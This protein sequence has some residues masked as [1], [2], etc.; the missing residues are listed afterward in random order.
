M[1]QENRSY[2]IR[3]Q[4]GNHEPMIH[5]DMEQTIDTFEI[6]S[7]KISQTSAY[8]LMNSD[9]GLIVGRVVANGGFGVPNAKVSVFVPYENTEDMKKRLMYYYTS[10]RDTNT[11]GIRYNL[12]P[13][14]LD[15]VCHQ[16]VGTFPDKRVLLDNDSWIEIF[17]KYY[18]YTTRTNN[19]GDYMIYGAPIGTQTIHVDVDLSDIGVLSQRPRDMVYKGANINQFE[20]PNKFRVDTNLSSLAQ[21]FTEDKTIYVYPFW[22]DTTDSDTGA[23]VTR[24]DI[25]LSYKFEPTCIFMGSII[26]DTGENSLSKKCVAHKNQGKMSDMITGQGTIEMIRKTPD[27]KIEQYSVQGNQLIDS[28]GVW[29]YQIPMNLDYV[30]TDEF[31]NTVLTDDPNKGIATRARVRFRIGMTETGT[32]ETARKRARFLVP[33]NPRLVEEDYPKFS[34]TKEIDYEFG[35][36]TKDENFRDLL[37]NKV[38]TVKSYIPRLQKSVQPQNKK[39][40]GIKMVNHSGGNN[41]MPF[42]NLSIKF[43][44]TYMFL[45]ALLKVLVTVVRLTNQLICGIGWVFYSLFDMCTTIANNIN[46]E[47]VYILLYGFNNID[48]DDWKRGDF[49]TCTYL[50]WYDEEYGTNLSRPYTTTGLGKWFLKGAFNIGCGIILEG[51]CEDENGN[52]TSYAPGS[53]KLIKKLNWELK[54]DD[55]ALEYNDAQTN[56]RKEAFSCSPD[57]AELYNCIENQLAQDNEV[58]SFNFVNDWVNGVLYMPLWFR[59]IK[60]KRRFLFFNL[61]A[62]DQWCSSDKRNGKGIFQRDLKLYRTCA[63]AMDIEKDEEYQLKPLAADY[64]TTKV[65]KY[66]SERNPETGEEHTDFTKKDDSN[67]YGYQCHKESRS[68]IPIDYGIITEKETIYGE[69]V[70][71]YRPVDINFS[72]VSDIVTLY[73]TDIIL[74]GSLNDC[75]LHGIPQFFK[76]LSSTTYN[77]PSD[78]L[79][80]DFIYE[81]SADN[82]TVDKYSMK[83]TE[84]TGSDWGNLGDDQSGSKESKTTN[85][86]DNGGLFYGI[87]CFDSYTKPKSCINLSRICEFGV[88]LDESQEILNLKLVD[89]TSTEDEIYD[90]YETLI[91]DGY[92]SYDEIYDMDYRSMFATLNGNWLKTKVNDNTGLTEYDFNR[93]YVENF[94]GVLH[95]IME[96]TVTQKPTDTNSKATYAGNYNLEQY[97][98]D[99]MKFRYGAYEKANGKYLYFYDYYKTLRGAGL[100]KIE[101]NN[102]RFPRFENS[103]YFYFGLNEGKT[104]IDKFRTNYFAECTNDTK[105]ELAYNITFVPNPWCGDES[106]YIKFDTN[107]PTPISVILTDKNNPNN[108]YTATNINTEKFYVGKEQESNIDGYKYI[109]LLGNNNNEIA[110]L[111]TGEYK[112]TLIDGEEEEYH[113]TIS[114]NSE[115]INYKYNT[116]AFIYNGSELENKYLK[117]YVNGQIDWRTTFTDIAED[118]TIN[119]LSNNRVIGGAIIIENVTVDLFKIY[120]KPVNSEFFGYMEYVKFIKDTNNPADDEIYPIFYDENS[121]EYAYYDSNNDKI[122]VGSKNND[123]NI[124]WDN[125]I[126]N[127]NPKYEYNSNYDGLE[128]VIV[129]ND[130][131]YVILKKNGIGYVNTISSTSSTILGNTI[132]IGVPYCDQKY[133]VEVV[134]I[135]GTTDEEGNVSFEDVD[136][137]NS[138]INTV[139][140]YSRVFTM[141]ING[142]DYDLIRNFKTGWVEKTVQY[143]DEEYQVQYDSDGN[144]ITN[145]NF[146]NNNIY[147]WN[148]LDNIGK[149]VLKEGDVKSITE[150]FDGDSLKSS[151]IDENNEIKY[152]NELMLI[153]DTLSVNFEGNG[154]LIYKKVSIINSADPL[155]PPVQKIVEYST[156]YSWNNSYCYNADE[157]ESDKLSLNNPETDITN[158]IEKMDEIIKNRIE[159]TKQVKG[160]F[161][162]EQDGKT[163]TVTYKSTAT[164]IDYRCVGNQF[165]INNEINK[166]NPGETSGGNISV[167]TVDITKMVGNFQIIGDKTTDEVVS[168]LP[169]LTFEDNSY[170]NYDECNN[171]YNLQYKLPYYFRIIDNNNNTLPSKGNDSDFQAMVPGNTENEAAILNVSTMFGVHIYNKPMYFKVVRYWSRFNNYNYN[172]HLVDLPGFLKGN[173]V[174]GIEDP[175]VNISDKPDN[176]LY[177]IVDNPYTNTEVERYIYTDNSQSDKL[178]YGKYNINDGNNNDGTDI[179]DSEGDDEVVNG[180]ITPIDNDSNSTNSNNLYQYIEIDNTNNKTVVISDGYCSDYETELNFD[181]NIDISGTYFMYRV[182]QNDRNEYLDYVKL[183]VNNAPSNNVKYYVYSYVNDNNGNSNYVYDNLT[184]NKSKWDSEEEIND[185]FITKYFNTLMV[186]GNNTCI[187]TTMNNRWSLNNINTNSIIPEYYVPLSNLDWNKNTTYKKNDYV[188]YSNKIYVSL[189]NDN[190]DKNP[191]EN[192][193]YWKEVSTSRTDKL[194]QQT[195]KFF[196]LAACDDKYYSLSPVIDY[197][198]IRCFALWYKKA[199]TIDNKLVKKN[200]NKTTIY[201]SC[202]ID[203]EGTDEQGNPIT[204]SWSDYSNIQY[205]KEGNTITLTIPQYNDDLVNQID[206]E[207]RDIFTKNISIKT[208]N[209]VNIKIQD[210]EKKT[211]EQGEETEVVVIKREKLRVIKIEF[212]DELEIADWHNFNIIDCMGIRRRCIMDHNSIITE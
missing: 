154:K 66:E 71:Y 135:C 152:K 50:E 129:K 57:V 106:G 138:L 103:F 72:N 126:I 175:V 87:T 156:P 91:P 113:D 177:K 32:E 78:L 153:G 176:V 41:P 63:Q 172:G 69:H 130:G 128:M 165:G 181:F 9:S 121:N 144:I 98:Q 45:C 30:I 211:N 200:Q 193:S 80:E 167:V 146:N 110:N 14:Q 191:A 33:N 168:N 212:G 21:I 2:R 169:T 166:T 11:Q 210:I 109:K 133:K 149:I 188:K 145:N 190:I 89:N 55:H 178:H 131:G 95:D 77:M 171:T 151:F 49:V 142:I 155:A 6:L 47:K 1:S 102:K 43:N 23:A 187:Y 26:T 13:E 132:T 104:A 31:G 22:G 65:G 179:P 29:C 51:L 204:L 60:P 12:L 67:C 195:S 53:S 201:L 27:N 196:I 115:K 15:D 173:V 184:T 58:T 34:E 83:M 100:I 76:A 52:S 183:Q 148:D 3:T 81:E 160:A 7:L 139:T 143:M 79:V 125:S 20:S 199:E 107:L 117:Y 136:T 111:P 161:C 28:D 108:V 118:S 35:S 114:F 123:N 46:W 174:N 84:M 182:S 208:A 101:D 90:A 73:A 164:P 75:D 105:G 162:Y 24:C 8:K 56:K 147:G 158:I 197:T 48:E 18:K 86:Y 207:Y 38:Y 205:L 185:F 17:D 202:Q 119:R 36:K 40:L 61:K 5:V 44:F 19:S 209:E 116:Q 64:Y 68:Y 97:S 157:W 120:V 112:I 54:R 203:V 59:K 4:V 62:K 198:P 194:K 137:E 16:S 99:Y 82:D 96:S 37:W 186:D 42:N 88:S 141:Y 189:A 180:G 127:K 94:D 192:T 70:Y 25:N 74:L 150:Y 122:V 159:F 134:E 140:V 206:F 85:I 163:L 92:I 39:Y 10:T 124:E 170:K 93:L